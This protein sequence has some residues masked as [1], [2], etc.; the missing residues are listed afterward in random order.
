MAYVV[1]RDGPPRGRWPEDYRIDF[2][3]N[4]AFALLSGWGANERSGATTMQ[5]SGGPESSMYL[6]L[7]AQTDRILETRL[8]PLAYEGS[9]PQTVAGWPLP[10]TTRRC[11]GSGLDGYVVTSVGMIIEKGP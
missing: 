6:Y 5:W 10:S 1:K 4:Q 9:P 11:G 3:V 8:Q 7:E 2:G